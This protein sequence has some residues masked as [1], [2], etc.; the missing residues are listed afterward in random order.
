MKP[1]EGSGLL[2]MQ[3]VGCTPWCSTDAPCITK[4]RAV[5]LTVTTTNFATTTTTN[6]SPTINNVVK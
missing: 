5:K 1:R 6:N 2:P 3:S 4:C